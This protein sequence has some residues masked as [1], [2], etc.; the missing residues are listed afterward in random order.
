MPETIAAAAT[1]IAN[2]RGKL[3]ACDQRPKRCLNDKAPGAAALDCNSGEFAW[4]LFN[5]VN[6]QP[7]SADDLNI[8]VADF[9]A[10]CIAV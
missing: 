7:Y 10:Q 3:I 2:L 8:E 5:S 4:R 6:V 1:A 9:L